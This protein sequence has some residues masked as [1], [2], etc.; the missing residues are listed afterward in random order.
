MSDKESKVLEL[1]KADNHITINE[2]IGITGF[3]RPTVIRAINT[4]KEYNI[5]ELLKETEPELLWFYVNQIEAA[6]TIYNMDLSL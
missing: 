2:I 5:F 4:L 6:A 1:I 3:S